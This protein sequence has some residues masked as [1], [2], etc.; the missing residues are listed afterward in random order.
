MNTCSGWTAAICGFAI[1]LLPGV[2]LPAGRGGGLVVEGVVRDGVYANRRQG[3]SVRVPKQLGAAA[4][5]R[6]FTAEDQSEVQLGDKA[7]RRYYVLVKRGP[8]AT[9]VRADI[10]GHG[11]EAALSHLARQ[12]AARRHETLAETLAGDTV[13]GTA[14]R[15]HTLADGGWPCVAEPSVGARAHG[16]AWLFVHDRLLY[17]VG[18]QVA[19]SQAESSS[20]F[21]PLDAEI[22]GLLAGLMTPAETAR[23]Q[24][25]R[26]Q[27]GDSPPPIAG[28]HLGDSRETLER[29]LGKPESAEQPPGKSETTLGFRG[30][31]LS[32]TVSPARGVT[33]IRL[34]D[35]KA[36]DIDGF[37]VGDTLAAVAG[38]WGPASTVESGGAEM[39]AMLGFATLQEYAFGELGFTIQGNSRGRIV[40]VDMFAAPWDATAPPGPLPVAGPVSPVVTQTLPPEDQLAVGQVFELP[41]G[42]LGNHTGDSIVHQR[43]GEVTSFSIADIVAPARV[44][45]GSEPS[46]E[47]LAGL[48]R[49]RPVRVEVTCRQLITE[50]IQRFEARVTVDGEDVAALLVREGLA[51]AR[52]NRDAYLHLLALESTARAAKRGLWGMDRRDFGGVT[53]DAYPPVLEQLHLYCADAYRPMPA[54]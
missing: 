54:Q 32:V 11:V 16:A 31:G 40:T 50:A 42:A 49:G 37:R 44:L 48:L 25:W 47:R 20:A 23:A 10:A 43:E 36:G 24:H 7:C 8:V 13:K 15:L 26:W 35:R 12:L 34:T 19:E 29:S 46:K 2:S 17:E 3:F 4:W 39:E 45:P 1:A 21:A 9:M 27:P 5:V 53:P 38:K 30:G 41:A 6:D 14:L 18:Y 52:R 33:F 28:I 22:D 51:I